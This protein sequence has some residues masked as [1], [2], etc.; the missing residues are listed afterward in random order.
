MFTCRIE[1]AD[2][3]SQSVRRL[4]PNEPGDVFVQFQWMF[5]TTVLCLSLPPRLP[6]QPTHEMESRNLKFGVQVTLERTTVHAV[7]KNNE[8]EQENQT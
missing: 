1:E 5:M 2:P 6:F 4:I 7:N 3:Q 8:R